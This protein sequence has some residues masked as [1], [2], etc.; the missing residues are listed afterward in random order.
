MPCC[1]QATL[2]G[3]RN[4]TLK[5]LK[6]SMSWSFGH[7]YIL[8]PVSLYQANQATCSLPLSADGCDQGTECIDKV[9]NDLLQ[10]QSLFL[11][12]MYQKSILLVPWLHIVKTVYKRIFACK[13]TNN[14]CVIILVRCCGPHLLFA[15]R[16]H[17]SCLG[18]CRSVRRRTHHVTP[19]R[20]RVWRVRRWTTPS[21]Y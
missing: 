12:Y 7:R 2:P 18:W 9:T 6:G 11:M 17:T 10:F 16:L 5:P 8:C 14:I 15:T 13:L 19:R 4:K 3:R 21:Q 20:T 1:C